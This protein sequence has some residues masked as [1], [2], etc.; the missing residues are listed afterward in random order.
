MLC[1]SKVLEQRE[2]AAYDL[3]RIIIQG[4]VVDERGLPVYAIE[5][6]LVPLLANGTVLSQEAAYDFTNRNGEYKLSPDQAGRF[7]L[8]VQWNAP[9]SPSQPFLTRYYPGST[10]PNQAETLEVSPARHLSM[11]AIQLQRVELAKVPVAVSWSN[12]QPEPEAYLLFVNTLYPQAGV[13][14]SEAIHPDADGMVSIPV[15]FEYLASAQVDCDDREHIQSAFTPEL[16]FSLK[17]AKA[18]NAPLHFV[19]PGTPCRVWHPK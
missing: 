14:G 1:Y 16:N 2:Q 19:L 6:E 13:I 10:D 17:S 3:H 7:L 15:G 5:V 9:P 8:A 12:G 18:P 11:S 4:R